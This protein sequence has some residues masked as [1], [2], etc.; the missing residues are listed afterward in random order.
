M[1][2]SIRT[3]SVLKNALLPSKSVNATIAL[4][5]KL[6]Y[7]LSKVADLGVVCVLVPG[8]GVH[9]EHALELGQQLERVRLLEEVSG[10]WEAGQARRRTRGVTGS[11]AG[12][13]TGG[14]TRGEHLMHQ[15]VLRQ[16]LLEQ[17]RHG[18]CCWTLRS[19]L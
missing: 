4:F 15:G 9:H 2:H 3:E 5:N 13:V 8:P 18:C 6:Y 14:V 12:D 16:H 7:K 10:G 1:P 11:E 19:Q 17:G